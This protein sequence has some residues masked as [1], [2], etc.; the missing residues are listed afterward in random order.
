MNTEEV[1]ATE[2]SNSNNC[3]VEMIDSLP[4]VDYNDEN[5]ESYA[6]SLVDEEMSRMPNPHYNKTI[7]APSSISEHFKKKAP[8]LSSEYE[9]LVSRNGNIKR[10][11]HSSSGVGE[12]VVVVEP[13]VKSLLNDEHAWKKSIRKAKIEL[14]Y[15]RLELMN[16]EISQISDSNQK[17]WRQHVLSLQKT[18]DAMVEKVK[19]QQLEVD[20]INTRRK[21]NQEKFANEVLYP[22]ATDYQ[23]LI[24]HIQDY[25]ILKGQLESQIKELSDK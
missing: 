7:G 1:M 13:P 17:M 10:P 20:V 18:L 6:L 2:N 15:K 12:D 14:E 19:A 21:E 11:P 22:S 8:I 3:K 5:F 9:A 4:Y 23:E 25:S 16:L 24:R